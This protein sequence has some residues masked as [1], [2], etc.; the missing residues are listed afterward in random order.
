[1]NAARCLACAVLLL[2]LSLAGRAR[3]DE[4]VV[5]DVVVLRDDT[6]LSGVLESWSPDGEAVLVDARGVTH[7]LPAQTVARVELAESRHE[8]ARATAETSVRVSLRGRSGAR[9]YFY[10]RTAA[11]YHLMGGTGGAGGNYELSD[12][13]LLCRAPCAARLAPGS[14]WLAVSTSPTRSPMLARE[15]VNI[16]SD[17]TLL[18]ETHSAAGFRIAGLVIIVVSA[19][20]GL[21]IALAPLALGGDVLRIGALGMSVI[22]LGTGVS[23][24]FLLA[25]DDAEITAR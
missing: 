4:P 20:A 16:D 7:R 22:L 25:T 14:A 3:A 1:M 18:G 21:L 12:W 23:I 8:A 5:D 17:V 11:L 2:A 10:R 24:P 9:P 13:E 15:A 19:L 6:R